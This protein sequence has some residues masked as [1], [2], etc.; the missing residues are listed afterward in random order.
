MRSAMVAALGLA[1]FGSVAV[2]AQ[3]QTG[4]VA[5]QAVGSRSTAVDADGNIRVPSNYRTAYEFLGSWA[6]AADRGSGAK[7][8]HIVYASPGAVAAYRKSGRFPDGT[9]LVKE[10]YA[11]STGSMTTGTVSHEQAL[12]GWFVMVAN[13]KNDH[14]G[15]KLWGDGWGWSWFDA[16]NPLKTTSTDYKADCQGCHVPARATQWIYVQGY[17]V[18]H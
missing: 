12:Q 13:G 18:L 2:L 11:A 7:Q 17:P 8:M 1:L 6:V 4:S 16:G 15:N 3:A 5:T 10:V 14:S 9:V